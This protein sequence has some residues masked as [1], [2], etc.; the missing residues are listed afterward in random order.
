MKGRMLVLLAVFSVLFMMMP[1]VSARHKNES[2]VDKIL[3][4]PLDNRPIAD[5]RHSR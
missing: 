4:V 1:V 2:K 3:Y 5:K